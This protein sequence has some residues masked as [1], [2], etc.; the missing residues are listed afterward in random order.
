M[1]WNKIIEWLKLSPKYL[2]SVGVVS[3][4][5]LFGPDLFLKRL[6]LDLFIA[7]Y[8][9][10]IGVVFLGVNVLLLAHVFSFTYSYFSKKVGDIRF[11][12]KRRKRLHSLTDEEKSILSG[13]IS[14]NT[15]SQDFE[16]TN[17]VVLGLEMEK[18]IFRVSSLSSYFTNFPYNIQPWAWEYLK[19]NPELLK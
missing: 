5:L 18:I 9:K 10:Y 3:G 11:L 7:D 4:A 1:D 13:Y 2:F 19:E 16:C 17:G 12:R 14:N 6:G 8:R 15:R